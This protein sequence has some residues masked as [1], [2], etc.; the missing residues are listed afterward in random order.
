MTEDGK[1][2]IKRVESSQSTD[3]PSEKFLE[4]NITGGAEEEP[5]E[6]KK[7]VTLIHI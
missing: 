1:F 5:E 2:N 4:T 3:E 6:H 7:K